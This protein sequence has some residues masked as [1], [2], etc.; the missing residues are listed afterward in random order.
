MKER[1]SQKGK[2]EQVEEKWRIK[3]YENQQLTAHG[4]STGHAKDFPAVK[5]GGVGES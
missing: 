5:Q 2:W 1:K 4:S 3:W